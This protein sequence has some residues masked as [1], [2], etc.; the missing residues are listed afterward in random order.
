MCQPDQL[1][2]WMIGW[3][4][5]FSPPKEEAEEER[6]KDTKTIQPPRDIIKSAPATICTHEEQ[7]EGAS[8]DGSRMRADL[9]RW[10]HKA[11]R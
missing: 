11:W 8:L 6:K 10:I 1:Q 3:P 5:A 9:L 7:T 4:G 2:E